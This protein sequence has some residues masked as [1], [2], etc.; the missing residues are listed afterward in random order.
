M[1][2]WLVQLVCITDGAPKNFKMRLYRNFNLKDFWPALVWL[3]ILSL[4]LT[5][6]AR[7]FLWSQTLDRDTV[8]FF[9]R[10]T[11]VGHANWML[12]STLL[13]TIT[14]FFLA[15][16]NRNQDHRDKFRQLTHK[17]G[18]VFLSITGAGVIAVLLKYLIGR[19]RPSQ[20][21]EYGAYYLSP[22]TTN[23]EL[24]SFPS[25]HSTNIFALAFSLSV[26]FP[27]ARVPLLLFASGIAFS[28]VIIGEHFLSDFAGG[29]LLAYVFVTWWKQRAK[30]TK[31][32][33]GESG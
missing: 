25:G 28:R 16:A 17:S 11:Q 5:Q 33:V 22:T 13:V 32:Y 23:S 15:K 12:G 14:F 19:A 4:A 6:D 26:F 10:I 2:K 8:A 7:V 30:I 24:A 21:M 20:F 29:A 31:P 1:E 9:Q 18:F 27:Q 3:L